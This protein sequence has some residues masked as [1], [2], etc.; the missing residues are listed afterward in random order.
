[1]IAVSLQ[2]LSSCSLAVL[3]ATVLNVWYIP[4]V[5][6]LFVA[7]EETVE[8]TPPH[9][10]KEKALE[11]FSVILPTIKHEIIKSRHQWDHHEPRMWSRARGISDAHLTAFDLEDLVL[12]R[13]G[14]TSY[15]TIL[16]GKIRIP[17][18]ENGYIHVRVHD[19][20]N[21]GEE[22]VIFHSLW[23]DEGNLN[24]DGQPT[25]WNAIQTED[26]PL[27]FFNE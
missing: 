8:F 7:S 24:S 18:I 16:L 9:P 6:G 25:T 15:G 2:A 23:T 21:R 26:T 19:P 10:P 14:L 17:A 4:R 27:E 13:A 5:N 1:M 3:R 20:P 22:D 12:V 11:A